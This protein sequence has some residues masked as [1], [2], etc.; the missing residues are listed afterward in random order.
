M[1]PFTQTL[2]KK[3]YRMIRVALREIRA[4]RERFVIAGGAFRLVDGVVQVDPNHWSQP[5][6]QAALEIRP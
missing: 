2:W 6:A 4:G 3:H 5:M 1:N